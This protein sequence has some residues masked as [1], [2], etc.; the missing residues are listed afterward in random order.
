M[1]QTQKQASHTIREFSV[2]ALV[3]VLHLALWF[4]LQTPN[5]SPVLQVKNQYETF[6]SDRAPSQQV[7]IASLI[8]HLPHITQTQELLP[9]KHKNTAVNI[10]VRKT[11]LNHTP[12][13]EDTEST[14]SATAITADSL[15]PQGRFVDGVQ[16]NQQ[17]QTS[18]LDLSGI[19][20]T[21]KNIAAQHKERI[22]PDTTK[23]LTEAE[24]FE[25]AVGQ[26]GLVDCKVKH[27]HLGILAIPLL[28]KDAVSEGGC[29][30]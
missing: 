19:K 7:M 30:W 6:L 11:P 12:T 10:P 15:T 14:N 26:S 21:A 27:A 17:D 9:P 16:D 2:I 22:Y 5:K 28:L 24:K 18:T 20:Q 4:A 3:L 25:Q 29:K 8:Q 1:M 13:V 23:Q